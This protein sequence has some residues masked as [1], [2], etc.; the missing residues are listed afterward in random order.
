MEPA[1]T[2]FVVH[3]VGDIAEGIEMLVG[4]PVRAE[5]MGAAGR[6]RMET[7]FTWGEVVNRLVSGFE[8]V[9]SR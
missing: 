7:Q 4:D 3:G 6:R 9:A 8:D 1:R 2:G 5:E